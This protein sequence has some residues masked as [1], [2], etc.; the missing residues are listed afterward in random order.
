MGASAVAYFVE[1]Y[2]EA[3]KGAAALAARRATAGGYL[4]VRVVD[5]A[6]A[7]TLGSIT[8][9]EEDGDRDSCVL[10]RVEHEPDV[11]FDRIT[12]SGTEL[13]TVP[14]P[15]TAAS[16]VYLAMSGTEQGSKR[17]LDRL[18]ALFSWLVAAG[19][20]M[21]GGI[22]VAAGPD[23]AHAVA[24]LLGEHWS[25]TLEKAHD[26]L[27]AAHREQAVLLSDLR[28]EHNEL[29]IRA[30]QLERECDALRQTDASA[31][32]RD[33]VCEGERSAQR[34]LDALRATRLFRYTTGLRRA[35]AKARAIGRR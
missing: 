9:H 13:V 11:A 3:P 10:F 24:A 18:A 32:A 31:R 27:L 12:T 20:P 4:L 30:A 5:A 22:A 2:E 28:L 25:S 8:E 16:V 35:Y 1:E 26:D 19:T 29:V 6:A 21:P 23:P 14:A 7:A 33:D 15:P 34:D 17:V